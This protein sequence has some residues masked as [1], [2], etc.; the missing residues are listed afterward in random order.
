MHTQVITYVKNEVLVE[1]EMGGDTQEGM[2]Q[3][4]VREGE[5]MKVWVGRDEGVEGKG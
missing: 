4:Q 3:W 5:G 1:V 2:H